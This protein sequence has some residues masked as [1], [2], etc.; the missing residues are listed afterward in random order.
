MGTKAFQ[1]ARIYRRPKFS[2]GLSF[3][4]DLLNIEVA[5]SDFSPE[6]LSELLASYTPQKKFYTLKTGKMV[7]FDDEDK[8]F[9]ELFK[10]MNMIEQRRKNLLKASLIC[11]FIVPLF[12]INASEKRKIGNFF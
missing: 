7:K 11:R 9:E 4:N 2:V 8:T 10:T 6:E 5:S 1:N 3:N 12:G